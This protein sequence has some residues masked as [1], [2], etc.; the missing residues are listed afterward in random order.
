M[1][2]HKCQHHL[3]LALVHEACMSRTTIFV[4]LRRHRVRNR[5]VNRL[6]AEMDHLRAGLHRR[7]QGCP[8]QDE[9]GQQQRGR[10]SYVLTHPHSL[11]ILA[12]DKWTVSDYCHILA[13]TWTKLWR[14]RPIMLLA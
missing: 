1:S 10:L 8:E 13:L 9:D 2:R 7:A 6:M 12:C 3:Q 14:N 4:V 11:L 5:V